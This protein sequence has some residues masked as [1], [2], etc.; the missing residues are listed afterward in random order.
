MLPSMF[1]PCR[2]MATF[3]N[4]RALNPIYNEPPL[5]SFVPERWFLADI[6]N[7]LPDEDT[8][9]RQLTLAVV[10][11]DEYYESSDEHR[12]GVDANAETIDQH[13]F[14]ALLDSLAMQ[15]SDMMENSDVAF[16][17][18]GGPFR[19]P[20]DEYL[21]TLHDAKRFLRENQDQEL[22]LVVFQ[23]V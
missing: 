18:P 12:A 5:F 15:L 20:P 10:H 4:R 19:A 3:C 2:Q 6:F 11:D 16:T 17:E 22:Y 13:A 1:R 14:I 9:T 23:Y 8:N 21:K 7:G